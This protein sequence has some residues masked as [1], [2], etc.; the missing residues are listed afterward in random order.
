MDFKITIPDAL[1]NQP[2]SNRKEIQS[3][4][5][6]LLIIELGKQG[7]ITNETAAQAADMAQDEYE[8]FAKSHNPPTAAYRPSTKEDFY[9]D[10]SP[11]PKSGSGGFRIFIAIL[12]IGIAA[13]A[14]FYRGSLLSGYYTRQGLNLLIEKRENEASRMFIEAVKNN[15]KNAAASAELAKYYIAQAESASK[16]GRN[17][18]S[19]KEY[20]NAL[21]YLAKAI[22]ADPYN[23]HTLFDAGYANEMLGD[24]ALAK[25]YYRKAMEAEPGYPSAALRLDNL[26]SMKKLPAAETGKPIRK[27]N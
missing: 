15:P 3:A 23:P 16:A 6:R 22:E 25:E 21:A 8:A 17:E 18:D 4:L 5:T 27:S 9:P 19:A 2:I 11:A 12:L 24:T 14:V 13:A 7:C 20:R 26:E 10:E 1:L